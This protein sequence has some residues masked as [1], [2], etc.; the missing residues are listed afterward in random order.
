V[1]RPLLLLSLLTPI[2]FVTSV[3]GLSQ[4][5]VSV[6]SS[7]DNTLYQ[8][9]AGAISNGA[10]QHIFVGRT[11]AGSLRRALLAFDVAGNIPAGSHITGATLTLNM[12]QTSSGEDSIRM[13]RVAA[14]WGEGTSAALGNEGAGAPATTN[15][16]TWIHR[17]FNTVFWSQAGSDY[18]ST[19]SATIAV[20]ALGAYVW[21]STDAMVADVQQWL[22]NPS[23]NF[24]W[25]LIGD[26]TAPHLTK[27]FD[28]RENTT[29]SFRPSLT[30][31]YSPPAGTGPVPPAPLSFALFQ[32]YP[33]PFN[34]STNIRFSIPAG[35][36][37]PTTL[38][39]YDI[40][41]KE[42]AVLV[43]APL[44][45]GSYGMAFHGSNLP[46]GLYFYQL[47]VGALRETR[48]MMLVR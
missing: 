11:S 26:E 36:S 15:D 21:G 46:S 10:G 14:D 32:N 3:P 47:S 34:P 38:K 19:P 29:A 6:V 24:G 18:S 22:D 9:T 28:S 44:G 8:D 48:S 45:P 43:N 7:K 33:N 25:I 12:S 31:T 27:R 16:A 2:I 35:V 41:G 17:F 13:F 42:V 40:L 37:G 30:V 4:V 39:V 23:G 5:Q 1:K 20:S